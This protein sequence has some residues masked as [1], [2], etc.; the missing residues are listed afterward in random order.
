MSG[1]KQVTVRVEVFLTV[2]IDPG[3]QTVDEAVGDLVREMDYDFTANPGYPGE[4][5]DMEI[6]DH[7]VSTVT[8]I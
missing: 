5:I 1:K 7:E 6:T 3:T 2:Q 8:N 4:I